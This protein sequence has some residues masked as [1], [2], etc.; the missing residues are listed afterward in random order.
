MRS[1][2]A[3]RTTDWLALR[4]FRHGFSRD[5]LVDLGGAV[6]QLLQDLAGVLAVE[7][8]VALA[9]ARAAGEDVGE[10]AAADLALARMLLL[11]EEADILEMRVG[12][13]V[14]DRVVA[15]RRHV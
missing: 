5:H 10:L 2:A 9:L 7:R 13:Q 1:F 15:R 12:H 3:L 14:V 6:A 4:R 8:S 11:A